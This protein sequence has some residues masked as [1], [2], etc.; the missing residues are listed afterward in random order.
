LLWAAPA[1]P[2][3]PSPAAEPESAARAAAPAGGDAWA[4]A[5]A[6]YAPVPEPEIDLPADRRQGWLPL[7]PPPGP[8]CP[9]CDPAVP[10]VE[11]TAEDVYGVG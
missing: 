2:G 5:G 10:I 11:L 6:S 3:Q 8:G 7:V 9:L 1:A 4:S